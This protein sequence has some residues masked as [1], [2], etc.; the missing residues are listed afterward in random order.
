MIVKSRGP[1]GKVL[2]T[3]E[4]PGA[5]WAES[6]HVVADFNQWSQSSLPMARRADS[7]NWQVTVTLDA[8]KSYQFRY[9][10]NSTT[11]CND[12]DADDYVPGPYGMSN[13]VVRT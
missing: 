12:H 8:G 13:S 9:L 10:V 5:V 7:A 4:F 6:V 11:W 1:T 3:F 2:V